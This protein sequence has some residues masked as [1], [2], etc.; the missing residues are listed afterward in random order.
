MRV[1]LAGGGT[2]G[3]VQPAVALARALEGEEIYFI[4]TAHGAEAQLIPRAGLSFGTIDIS[5]F[6]RARPLSLLSLAPRASR[7]TAQ[8][9]SLLRRR[10][11]DVVVGMGGYVSL[12]VCAAA[13]LRGI[14]IVL[15]EQN[16]VLG[17][18]NRVCK[19]FASRVAV[20]W[21]GTLPAAG[22]RG[23]VTGNP[24]L[25]EIAHLDL[26]RRRPPAL[27]RF[28]L[29]PAR[30]T[31]LVFG[32]SQG[33]RRLNQAAGGL[34]ERW[35]QRPDRQVLHIVGPADFATFKATVADDRSMPYRIVDYLSEMMDAYS[36]A[37]LVLCRGGATT[38]AELTAVGLPAIIVPYP[39][40]RDRQQELHGQ[41]LEDAGAAI[42]LRDSDTDS[43]SVGELADSLLGSDS[44]LASMSKASRGLG[45]PDAADRLASVVRGVAA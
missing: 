18:A 28:E 30:R 40:H 29:E 10:D 31:L 41:V 27:A 15:H 26:E 33:A 13:R 20:S 5:G 17:L 37:D 25:P 34:A 2:A 19:R 7:A 38:V 4:G 39:F 35:K 44:A 21:D 24:V 14:P 45:H 12:P 22:P 1:V 36:V 11:P 6:D 23:V 16:A 3:H 9:H 42:V 43:D 8:A 32:G